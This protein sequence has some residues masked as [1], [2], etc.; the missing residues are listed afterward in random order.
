MRIGGLEGVR[1]YAAL[2]TYLEGLSLVRG[3]SL[4]E[5]SGS[6][7]LLDLSVRGDLELL[8]RIFALDGRL[9][10]APRTEPPAARQEAPDFVWQP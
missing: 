7:A 10:P 3:V 6:T 2:T 1:S 8:R 9:A 4:R 5:L